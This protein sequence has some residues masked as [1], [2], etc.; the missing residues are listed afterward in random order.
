MK[1]LPAGLQD[2]LDSRVTTLCWC[3]KLVRTDG[4]VLGFTDHDQ[5]VIFDG[6]T[7]EAVT[8][9]TGTAVQNDLGMQVPTMEVQGALRSDQLTEADLSGGLWDN[10]VVELWRVNWS[11]TS[12]RVQMRKGTVGEV[13]RGEVAFIA[14]LRGLAHELN[15]QMGRLYTYSC[16]ADLGD[17]RCTV[18]LNDPSFKGSGTVSSIVAADRWFVSSGLD[19]FDNNLFTG[20]K[21]TWTSGENAGRTSEVRLHTTR[22]GGVQ[23]ELWVPTGSPMQVGDEFTVT[24]GCD[25]QFGTC[26]FVFN[27]AINFRG[28]P[29]MPSNDRLMSYPK[30]NLDNDGGS[31]FGN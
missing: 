8:G 9:F 3:W 27:N 21:V 18:N 5:N 23:I 14:E 10:A 19:G 1:T 30:R 29:W 15:Q 11:N 25:K 2:H 24:A 12:Q 16:D 26:R 20:G 4:A 22:L 6:V 31:L 7:Y 17:S 13:K 28:F